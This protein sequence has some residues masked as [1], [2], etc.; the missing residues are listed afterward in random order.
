MDLK[1]I[2]EPITEEFKLV[3]ESISSALSG[4]DE[5]SILEM[6]SFVAD[7]TGKKIR[8]ALVLLCGKVDS[9]SHEQAQNEKELVK[10]ATAVELIHMA[11]LIHDDVLDE[12]KMRH[13]RP[14]VNAKWG[15]AISI[16]FGNYVYSRAFELIGQSS[17]A[18]V[19]SCFSEALKLMCEGELMHLYQRDDLS[20][21]K[22]DYMQ[23]A[24]NKTASLFSA[25]CYAGAVIG[26]N[27]AG[28]C[29]ALR[30]FG[31]DL[32]IA[33]QIID[34]CRDIFSEEDTLGK[35]PGQDVMSGDVTLPVLILLESV[36]SEKRDQL[37]DMLLA[38]SRVD[39]LGAIRDA[40]VAC[41]ALTKTQRVAEEYINSAKQRLEKVADSDYKKSLLMLAEYVCL[42]SAG[43]QG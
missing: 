42:S 43:I 33:F 32:G 18:E 16:V 21:S 11:S 38:G 14:S 20:M 37:R 13:N 27:Q 26:G 1:K 25:S 5:K 12:A 7:G 4:S 6:G 17:N 30:G 23:V 31:L 28:V 8:P 10:I 39:N 34:D 41:D 22:E 19:F 24:K 36:S 35:I 9:S 3:E 2:Y 29:E 40:L 15:N